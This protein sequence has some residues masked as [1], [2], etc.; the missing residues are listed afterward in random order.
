MR[1]KRAPL[2]TLAKLA[3]RVS[4]LLGEDVPA[5]TLQGAVCKFMQ[6]LSCFACGKTLS[7]ARE[8]D[9]NQK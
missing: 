9:S 7:R 8:E 2:L 5:V 1:A 3:R 4:A 6:A